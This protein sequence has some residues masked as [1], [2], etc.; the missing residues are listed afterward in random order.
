[1]LIVALLLYWMEDPGSSS[2]S[3]ALLLYSDHLSEMAILP[4]LKAERTFKDGG[5]EEDEVGLSPLSADH[6][7]SGL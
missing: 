4:R 1:M 2:S 6:K 7:A 3:S 5:C